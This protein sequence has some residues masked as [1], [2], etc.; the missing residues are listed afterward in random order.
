[1]PDYPYECL[2]CKASFSVFK[3]V[4]DIDNI[5]ECVSCQSR[6]TE[7]RIALS[8]LEKSS[9]SQPYYEPA[10]GCEIK[11]KSHKQ[12]ILKSRNLEEI[13]NTSPEQM[14]KDLEQPRIDK[15]EKSWDNL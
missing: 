6:N 2:D 3:R 15:I 12:Q 10:L 13:G 9:L 5:E 14:Y 7:R 11:S 1:M 8:N 4:A